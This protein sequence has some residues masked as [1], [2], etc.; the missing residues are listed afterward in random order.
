MGIPS[1]SLQFGVAMIGMGALTEQLTPGQLPRAGQG[2][3]TFRLETGRG[4]L[5]VA[6]FATARAPPRC[7][8]ARA[9]GWHHRLD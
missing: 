2:A 6:R 7:Q 1:L 4:Y 3:R 9:G 8:M 5:A